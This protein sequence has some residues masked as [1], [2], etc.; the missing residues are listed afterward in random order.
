MNFIICSLR[1]KPCTYI[2]FEKM[3]KILFYDDFI[4]S[5]FSEFEVKLGFDQC[6]MARSDLS[7]GLHHLTCHYPSSSPVTYITLPHARSSYLG[8]NFLLQACPHHRIRHVA[9]SCV[10]PVLHVV[11]I[12]NA[13][14][15]RL[16]R[17][18][19]THPHNIYP[20]SILKLRASA[21]HR[22]CHVVT[23]CLPAWFNSRALCFC[24]HA[25]AVD[26][27]TR[28][29]IRIHLRTLPHHHPLRG[30]WHMSNFCMPAIFNGLAT[31]FCGLT[32]AVGS[33]HVAKSDAPSWVATASA[34]WAHCHV[35]PS[36][37]PSLF[38]R[39]TSLSCGHPFFVDL[40]HVA[41]SG[42]PAYSAS[43]RHLAA[44]TGP[45]RDLSEICMPAWFKLHTLCLCGR[46]GFVHLRHV[47]AS[48]FCIFLD[49]SCSFLT[50]VRLFWQRPLPLENAWLYQKHQLSFK[51]QSIGLSFLRCLAA[52]SDAL[53]TFTR[54]EC[55]LK[56]C[57]FL[58]LFETWLICLV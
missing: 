11:S 55:H 41:T 31:L 39:R 45:A 5:H 46:A 53:E 4:F 25:P 50:A 51:L 54:P 40:R 32:P 27:L 15:T 34:T 23:T 3:L 20:P 28:G 8:R 19:I 58:L 57:D 29:G 17:G 1:L 48:F 10:S 52:P 44:P 47:A 33:R 9:A 37:I 56:N 36:R 43:P 49:M 24:G 12:S 13:R 6:H 35:A 22:S 14:E 26:P 38:K 42:E 16:P 7:I 18:V 2:L 21:H 30:R